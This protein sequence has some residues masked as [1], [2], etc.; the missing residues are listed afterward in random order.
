MYK[1][2]FPADILLP[3]SDPEKWSVI[4]CD[5][6]TSEPEYWEETARC[7]EGYPSAL[8][9]ILPEVYLKDDNS[10]RIR[11]I[12]GNMKKYLKEG[13]FEEYPGT[14]VLTLRKLKNGMVRKGIVG[15]I[16]LDDYSYEKNAQTLIRA[17]ESTVI[18]RIPPRVEIRRGATIEIPHIMLLM[19]D[20][21]RTVIEPA[22]D[23]ISEF[24]KLYDF[25]LM[26]NA[27]SISGYALSKEAAEDMSRNINRL[28]EE[29][30][31][32]IL[33]AVG[34]GNH[35]LAA[36]RECYRQGKG[37]AYALVEIVNIHDESLEFEP[38]YR[39]V[40]G[41]DCN[42]LKTNFTQSLG[43]EYHGSGSRSYTLVC[44]GGEEIIEVKAAAGLA[45]T[46]LQNFLD[47]YISAHPEVTVDYI[48]GRENL[49]KI[50][51]KPGTA[52]FL[53]EGMDKSDLFRAVGRDGSLP[54]KTFSMG[55]ADDKRFYLEARKI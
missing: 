38:I 8:N 33:F 18:E 16:N 28:A 34:D 29:S 54:R 25:T 55:C 47:G 42:D 44:G 36:A 24:R 21:G 15:L 31:T 17:T 2:F 43:G 46:D 4:A 1:Y 9:I 32:G 41:A 22:A 14:F 6:Y 49:R 19:D 12:N 27:G 3:E 39:V 53:F 52:G 20:S 11:Q 51:Q 7:A 37:P 10:A 48:H 26:Q 35:S 5:Q 30:G 23:K 45:V 40:F 50:C 13:I